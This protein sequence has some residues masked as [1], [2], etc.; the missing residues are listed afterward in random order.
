MATNNSVQIIL[1]NDTWPA[2]TDLP[3]TTISLPEY[4]G[5][6]GLVV[7]AI[8]AG[9]YILLLLFLAFKIYRDKGGSLTPWGYIAA[10]WKD[11][12]IYAPLIVH[13]YDTATGL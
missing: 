3:I 7:T 6:P 9:C 10:I 13:I 12:A 11:R 1:G 2:T 4:Q 8:Y 5:L